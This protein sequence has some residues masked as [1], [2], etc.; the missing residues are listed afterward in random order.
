M[1]HLKK[2]DNG[3]VILFRDGSAVASLNPNMKVFEHKEVPNAVFIT[4]DSNQFQFINGYLIKLDELDKA[5][6]SP[7]IQANNISELVQELSANFFFRKSVNGGG[8]SSLIVASENATVAP[9]ASH[10]FPVDPNSVINCIIQTPGSL[11]KYQANIQDFAN[12]S[13]IENRLVD[14]D[15]SNIWYNNSHAASANLACPALDLLS[16]KK[17]DYIKINWWSDVYLSTNFQIQASNDGNTWTDIVSGQ[18]AIT[19]NS[20]T[21]PVQTI[22]VSGTYRYWRL[23][24][25]SG[26]SSAYIVITEMEAFLDPGNTIDFIDDNSKTEVKGIAGETHVKNLTANAANIIINY[27]KN[28]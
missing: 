21:W 15:Y 25:V 14:G 4:D 12:I 6:S 13:T 11:Q 7:F 9:S 18:T 10:V 24:N 3:N 5:N 2:I 1:I 8:G 20:P 16:P 19:S 27:L 28:E 26:T 17:V 22:P 23:F